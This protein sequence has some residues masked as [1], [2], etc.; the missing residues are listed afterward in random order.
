MNFVNAI[1]EELKRSISGEVKAD[2]ITCQVY[3]VDASIYEITPLA[4]VIPKTVEDIVATVKIAKKHGIS[5]IPRGAATGITGG[6]LGSGIIIDISRHLTSIVEINLDQKYALCEPGVVQDQLNTVLMPDGYRLG[7]DTSTGDR[8]TLGGMLANNSAGARSL[9]YG[10]M[11]DHIE[12]VT[13]VLGSGEICTFGQLSPEEIAKKTL[14]NNAEG[15]IYKK[16]IIL[17]EKYRD[18]ILKKFPH[19]P[20]RVSGYNLD[21][22]IETE[23]LNLAKVICGSEGTLGLITSLKVRISKRPTLTGACLLFFDNLIEA[24]QQIEKILEF[25]PIAAEMIDKHIIEAGVKAPSVRGNPIL[26]LINDDSKAPHNR[27]PEAIF[28]IE[29][30][31][32][33]KE[34]LNEKLTRFHTAMKLQ[35]IGYTG[36]IINDAQEVESIWALRKAGLG[37]LLSKR[38]YNRAIAFI[39]DVSVA[40][41]NLAKFMGKFQACLKSHGKDAGIY[42][43]VGSGC[44]HI[45]PY[46]DLRDPKEITTM[47][48]M[49]EEVTDILLEC[50]GSL[51]GE[52]GDGLIRSWLNEKL[53]GK[54]L[55]QAFIDLKEAFDPQ[56]I[57][58]PNKI[59]K[60]PDVSENLRLSPTT[61]EHHIE[62]FLDFNREGGFNLAVDLCNGNGACRKPSKLMCPSFQATGDEI[63]TTRARAQA[64]RG[65]IHG[66]LKS[67]EFTGEGLY[68]VLDLCIECKGC[69]TECPSQV[70]MAKMKSEFLFHYYKKHGHPLRNYL[71]AHIGF[72]NTLFSPIATI[73]N[74]LNKLSVTKACLNYLGITSLRPSPELASKRFS[75]TVSA[76]PDSENEKQKVVLFNDTYTEFNEPHIGVAAHKVLSA[77]G[78]GV[79]IPPWRCCGRPLI[80][81][82]MLDKAQNNAIKLIKE[83]LPYAEQ[84]HSIIILEPSCLSA[85]KDDYYGL[86][87]QLGDPIRT[88]YE[89]VSSKCLSL[90]EFLSHHIINEK[91][92]LNLFSHE[93]Q[94]ILFHGHCHQ[95]A[96]TGTAIMQ[97]VLQALPRT[98]IKE[99][100][101]GC[102]GLAGSF[103]YEKEHYDISMKIANLT[104]VPFIKKQKDSPEL[105]ANGFSC[106][107]QINHGSG[108]K[109]LHIAEIIARKIASH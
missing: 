57:M 74:A 109:A 28:I 10:K 35:K 95:K 92:P 91:L 45:R 17:R 27:R 77:L 2:A 11:V 103:G 55:Y 42:G 68:N 67:D 4:V 97:K 83:L 104:L 81:K 19:I 62:T 82:G 34:G 43:H 16:I 41:E 7:P 32:E 25:H 22:L 37:L 5:I 89:T 47:K 108:K 106:R 46:I 105:V 38:T 26:S 84:G 33:T 12:E 9:I 73:F 24:L 85:L 71:F 102:C 107:A 39:E 90:E 76:F 54:K 65:I 51:S 61:K 36:H 96:L 52:H 63:H 98:D 99:I 20:R 13:M 44:M 49:M 40:P 94:Q 59:V 72:I 30:D 93:E 50:K 69:K 80:S 70:D 8:A 18:E 3:S 75:K 48:S 79:I 56:N 31:G 53:F 66:K 101:S 64:L 15:E 100:P 6:C 78:Y 14:Q 23:N 1:I 88:T 60:G 21:T 58:N 29:F 87:N 86:L